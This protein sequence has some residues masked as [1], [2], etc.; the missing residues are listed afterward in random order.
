MLALAAMLNEVATVAPLPGLLT[1]MPSE[2]EFE[3]VVAAAITVMAKS[4]TQPAPPV[5]HDL[6]CS[7]CAPVDAGTCAFSDVALTMVVSAL[8]SSE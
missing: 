5:P 3:D 2:L 1:L 7:V 4:V 6:T 8:E